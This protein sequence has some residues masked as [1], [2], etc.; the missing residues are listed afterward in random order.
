MEPRMSSVTKVQGVIR[1][2]GDVPVIDPHE[3]VV[4]GLDVPYAD[5]YW[6]SYCPRADENVDDAFVNSIRQ[7]N[8]VRDPI[9]V[10]RDG[11]RV[12]VLDG[13]RRVKA[14]RIVWREQA[15]AG[16]SEERRVVLRFVMQTGTPAELFQVNRSSHD[17]RKDLTPAQRALLMAHFAKH[18]DGLQAVATEFGCTVQTVRNSMALLK[19]SERVQ[20][21]VGAGTIAST[22]AVR[23]ARLSRVEQDA[24]LEQMIERGATRGAAAAEVMRADDAA[25]PPASRLRPIGF[26]E[27]WFDGLALTELEHAK[28]ARA[29]I[30]YVLGDDR[31]L[32]EW[33]QLRDGAQTALKRRR[34]Q[35]SDERA[36][37]AGGGAEPADRRQLALVN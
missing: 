16:V 4:V 14:A 21:A 25:P 8:E 5:A 37:D 36:L 1:R 10:C 12:L 13:R 27:R 3:P 18:V 19:C 31:A 15:A 33:P 35:A 30:G 6:F 34:R 28:I 26:F 20:Q 29:V 11:A 2:G 32:D 22:A 7:P 24:K 9:H 23:L 17:D